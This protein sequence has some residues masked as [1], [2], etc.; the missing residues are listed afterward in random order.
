MSALVKVS[1]VLRQGPDLDDIATTGTVVDIRT[2]R[3]RVLWD[4]GW[5]GWSSHKCLVLLWKAYEV[6]P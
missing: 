4:D 6:T 2:D 5:N 1:R 3:V